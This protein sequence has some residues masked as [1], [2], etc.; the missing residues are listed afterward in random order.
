[1][2]TGLPMVAG[3]TLA[4]YAVEQGHAFASDAARAAMLGIVA[5]GTFCLTYAHCGR[6]AGWPLS[7]LAGWLAFGALAAVFAEAYLSWWGEFAAAVIGLLAARWLMPRSPPAAA[8]RVP[9]RWDIGLRMAAAGTLVVVLTAVAGALGPQLSGILSAFPV[10]TVILTVFTHVQQGHDAVAT[11][12]RGLLGGL[13]GFAV[14]CLV[15]GLALA[16]LERNLAS[17]IAMALA[18]QV[19]IQAILVWR[20]TGRAT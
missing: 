11:F 5:T 7:V 13:H 12:L 18:A 20:A 8:I 3:P 1:V 9:P 19:L 14:Y 6:F 2:L 4:F 15:F 17:A 16:R 10:V